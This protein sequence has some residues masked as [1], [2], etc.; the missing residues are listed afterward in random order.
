MSAP[1]EMS[2]RLSTYVASALL[3]GREIGIVDSGVFSF[4]KILKDVL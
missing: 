4:L 2:A 1:S 3:G